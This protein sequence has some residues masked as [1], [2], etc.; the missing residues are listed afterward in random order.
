MY[1]TKSQQI[2]INQ[3][4]GLI[5]RSPLIFFFTVFTSSTSGLPLKTLKKAGKVI[6]TVEESVTILQ[7]IVG[8]YEKV[9]E[10]LTEWAASWSI[11]SWPIWGTIWAGSEGS[12]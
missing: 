3:A 5:C 10:R 2:N 11:W 8:I 1:L 12:N 7:K 4:G 6:K 9:E